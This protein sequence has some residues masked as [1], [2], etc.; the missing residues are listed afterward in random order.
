M[1]KAPDSQRYSPKLP[2]CCF[3]LLS[4]SRTS[5]RSCTRRGRSWSSCHPACRR[6][7]RLNT[8]LSW[9]HTS[10]WDL[11]TRPGSDA[12]AWAVGGSGGVDR[13][14]PA[15]V[16]DA[17]PPAVPPQATSDPALDAPF[18][19]A[20]RSNQQVSCLPRRTKTEFASAASH[21]RPW[22]YLTY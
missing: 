5:L 20:S 19:A 15:G 9:A 13:D 14:D 7:Q 8:R 2:S 1:E 16:T 17:I 3:A 11:T 6:P 22:V 18:P 4:L 10:T 21:S 12:H